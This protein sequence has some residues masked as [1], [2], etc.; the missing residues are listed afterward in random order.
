MSFMCRAKITVSVYP[1]GFEISKYYVGTEED[2]YREANDWMEQIAIE[3]VE[4]RGY[5]DGE[6]DFIFDYIEHTIE[7]DFETPLSMF[8]VLEPDVMDPVYGIFP[9]YEE[10]EQA[11]EMACHEWAVD[12]I[13]N[14]DPED[15][16]G[17]KAWDEELDYD[18]LVKNC[19]GTFRIQEV[20]VFGVNYK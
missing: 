11:I 15:V 18:W 7:W 16:I 6:K 1:I 20:P 8:A 3:L 10:A 9:T 2:I 12:V 19:R 14:Q 13:E 17:L 4:E 5:E